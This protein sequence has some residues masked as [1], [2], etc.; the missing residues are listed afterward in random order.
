MVSKVTMKHTSRSGSDLSC[1][2]H[3]P[4]HFN[5]EIT[6]PMV[7]RTLS[8]KIIITLLF[9]FGGL[10]FLSAQ[11]R[12][13]DSLKSL[14]LSQS[15]IVPNQHIDLINKLSYELRVSYPDLVMSYTQKALSLSKRNNYKI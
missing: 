2:S 11:N 7:L 6:P 3:R 1:P 13:L 9:L 15:A 8:V 5:L 4:K 14:A 10:T 12:K